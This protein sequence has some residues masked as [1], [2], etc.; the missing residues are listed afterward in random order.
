MRKAFA[1]AVVVELHAIPRP[2]LH[3]IPRPTPTPMLAAF[4]TY[5]LSLSLP[6]LQDSCWCFK[7][8]H[9]LRVLFKY[10]MNTETVRFVSTTDRH[11][12]IYGLHERRNAC[13][14]SCEYLLLSL[15][16][17]FRT[18]CSEVFDFLNWHTCTILMTTHPLSYKWF[19]RNCICSSKRHFLI[20]WLPVSWWTPP[21][22]VFSCSRSR[23]LP[24]LICILQLK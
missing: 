11:L 23:A 18:I 9:H 21:Y 22:V 3:A 15:I 24:T 16:S 4:L 14:S 17:K 19:C 6:E 2:E 5:L 7:C 20:Y 12:T 13:R 1:Q 8:A 10:N